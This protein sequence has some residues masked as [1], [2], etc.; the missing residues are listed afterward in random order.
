VTVRISDLP[1]HVRARID[2]RPARKRSAAKAQQVESD[3]EA[4]LAHHI[5]VAKLPPPARE[6]KF[7][8]PS[9]GWRFDFAWPDL[10]VA[11]EVEGAIHACGRHTRGVG[12]EVDCVKYNEAALLGWT[13]LRV[14][15]SQIESLAALRWIERALHLPGPE[16]GVVR[17]SPGSPGLAA[18]LSGP[19]NKG[20]SPSPPARPRRKSPGPA[21]LR[22][23]RS[24]P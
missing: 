7:H 14:T 5:R 12:F 18:L 6:W 13:V 15:D 4:H 8:H 23:P 3:L 17:G 11:V 19:D 20:E 22:P 10:L 9:R 2:T 1:A 24:I 16:E 21:A